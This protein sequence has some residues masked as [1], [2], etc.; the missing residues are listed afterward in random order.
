MFEHYQERK[1]KDI[2]MLAAMHGIKIKEEKK[3][4]SMIFGDPS[5]YSKLN[6]EDKIK[7]TEKMMNHFKNFNL[8]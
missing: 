4:E 2:E 5:E 6:E 8:L 7:Q 1:I 3:K